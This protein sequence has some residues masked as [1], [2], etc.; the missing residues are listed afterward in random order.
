[1]AHFFIDR[2]V[3]AWVI[4]IVI[5]LAGVL[6]LFNLPVE[7]YPNIAPPS[8]SIN[9]MYPGASAQTIENSVTQVIEQSLTGIDNMR[10]FFSDSNSAGL[11]T[12]TVT[13]EPE[14]DIDIAQVQ[15]QNRL[16]SVMQLLPQAV[17]QQGVTVTKSNSSF[18]LVAGF[19][20]EGGSITQLDLGDLLTSKV[21]DAVA[22]VDGVGNVIVFGEPHAMRIWLNPNKLQSYNMTVMDVRRAVQAQNTDVSA[23]QLG[24]LPSVKG[25]QVNASITAQSRLQTVEDFEKIILRVNS[26]GSQLRL[27]DVARLEMGART[28]TG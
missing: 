2:P 20:S 24:G 6:S 19:Y 10:Y 28:Y 9:T 22:R 11:S 4:A 14:A 23:G 5:M 13:F 12:I 26:D 25:Q 17:Q 15:V 16:Q 18:L 21:S 3:F 1:M 7:Q 8:V 27:R